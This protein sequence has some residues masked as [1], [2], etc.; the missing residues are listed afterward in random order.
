MRQS[1][2]LK[3]FTVRQYVCW[4]IFVVEALE[5]ELVHNSSIAQTDIRGDTLVFEVKDEFVLNAISWVC[6][7]VWIL[8]G[9]D[10]VVDAHSTI[11]IGGQFLLELPEASFLVADLKNLR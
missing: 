8:C 2:S 10:L 4:L 1:S 11:V 9:H 5:Y 6:G 3:L 7:A